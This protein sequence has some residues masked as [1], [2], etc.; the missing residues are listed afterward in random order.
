M[1]GVEVKAGSANSIN[2]LCLQ[3]SFVATVL[4]AL[5]NMHF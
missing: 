2:I 4:K 5:T 3:G 1:V